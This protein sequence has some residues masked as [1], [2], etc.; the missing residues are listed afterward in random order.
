MIRLNFSLSQSSHRK[1]P[2]RSLMIPKI[3]TN[4]I[5]VNWKPF[6]ACTKENL[7]KWLGPG[8]T[9]RIFIWWTVKWMIRWI[10]WASFR[11]RCSLSFRTLSFQIQP[12]KWVW[13]ICKMLKWMGWSTSHLLCLMNNKVKVSVNCQLEVHWME[14][15][16][17]RVQL[18]RVLTPSNRF[19][20]RTHNP[21][22]FQ[23]QAW[24]H[25]PKTTSLL[26]QAK[27]HSNQ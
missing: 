14:V 10:K 9:C 1:T 24:H 5:K 11:D 15:H 16:W 19:H 22:R 25:P 18:N 27:T 17:H 6:V 20:S 13:W 23:L 12:N 8:R 2:R 4:N 26:Q 7:R 3:K 21:F